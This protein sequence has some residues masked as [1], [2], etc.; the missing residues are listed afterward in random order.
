VTWHLIFR[1]LIRRKGSR[2]F[3][4]SD[5]NGNFP[6][7]SSTH[8]QRVFGFRDDLASGSRQCWL[9]GEPPEQSMGIE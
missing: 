6:G 8:D 2:Q 5:L 4:Q 7:G 9:I 3:A 1:Q